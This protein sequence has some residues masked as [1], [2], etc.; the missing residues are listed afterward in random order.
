MKKIIF[1]TIILCFQFSIFSQEEIVD[2]KFNK[3]LSINLKKVDFQSNINTYDNLNSSF[4][5]DLQAGYYYKIDERW[6]VKTGL[7]L[8]Y[9]NSNTRDYSFI[10]PCDITSSG[11]NGTQSYARSTMDW[12][13]VNIPLEVQF[14]LINGKKRIYLKGGIDNLFYLFG[15][16]RSLLHEC[17]ESPR[18]FDGFT[19]DE[20]RFFGQVNLGVGFEFN[21]NEE[22]KIYVEP[23]FEYAFSNVINIPA[24]IGEKV[25]SRIMNFGIL[26]G[27]RF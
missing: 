27:Y 13:Y 6:M 21:L 1:T 8:N 11:F 17:G 5:I 7:E 19:F 26:T 14:N 10:F 4:G 22:R 9:L 20:K 24:A 16:S 23:N 2:K 15:D 3:S 18:D 25:K 12:F